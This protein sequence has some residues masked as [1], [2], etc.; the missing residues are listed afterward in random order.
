MVLRV[1]GSTAI[2]SPTKQKRYGA[3]WMAITHR[4]SVQPGM[5]K[6]IDN[7]HDE[8]VKMHHSDAIAQHVSVMA[9]HTNVFR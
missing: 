1:P 5:D 6:Q 8:L 4:I 9:Q 7:G 2:G 3:G